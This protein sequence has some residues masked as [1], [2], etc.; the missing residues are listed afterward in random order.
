MLPPRSQNVTGK[1]LSFCLLPSAF[2][3]PPDDLPP[4]EPPVDRYAVLRVRD[5]QLYLIGRFVASFGQQML[6]TAVGW[7][8]YERTNSTLALGFVGLT[9]IIPLL[10]LTLPAGHVADQRERRGI[11]LWMQIMTAAATAGLT[12]VSW[13]HAA[14]PWTYVFLLLSG[15]ARA[16][17]WPASGA[18][19]PQLVPRAMFPTAIM[20]SSGSFQFSAALGPVVGGIVVARTGGATGVYAFNVL[21]ALF[22]GVMI[23]LVQARASAPVKREKMTTA[24]LAAGVKFV[25]HTP[26]ILG[27]ISLDLFAV[28]LGGATALL[29]VYARDVLHVGARGLGELRAATPVGSMAMALVLAHRPPMEKAGRSLLLAVAGFGLATMIF[30]LSHLFWLSLAMLFVLGVLDNISVVVRQTLVQVLTPDAMRGRV[31]AVNSLFI[32]AS[33]EFGSF[34]SGLVAHWFGSV[35]AVVSGGVGTIL[36]VIATALIWPQLRRIGRLDT[37]GEA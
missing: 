23:W 7:D 6:G 13:T 33:N 5:F 21:A 17:L 25:F 22:C 30:G 29:P 15:V 8:L 34:E 3:K 9:Q 14:V 19:L 28:L 11:I 16:F 24:N 37:A 12:F 27:T 36:V 1:P 20:W 2:L 32:G 18:I 10:L 4:T 31:S 26:V 35:F